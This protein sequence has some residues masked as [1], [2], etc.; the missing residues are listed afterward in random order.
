MYFIGADLSKSKVDVYVLDASGIKILHQ[1][2]ANTLVKLRVFF[3]THILKRYAI[4]P[5]QI[6]VCCENTGI[7]GRP[8]ENVCLAEGIPLWVE[9]ALRIKRASS[10]LRGKSDLLDSQR[11]A[12]Y[13]LRYQDRKRMVQ[14][15]STST[16]QL[17]GLLHARET[18]TN[19]INRLK[20][21][22][23]EACKFDPELYAVLKSSFK[24]SIQ[25]LKRQLDN[26]EQQI[27]QTLMESQELRS[28]VDLMRSIPGVGLIL[29]L[30]LI[31]ATDNFTAFKSPKQL[32]CHCG[33]VPFPNESG[34]IVKRAK[35]SRHANAKLKKLLH[36][37]AMVA[38]QHNPQL[39]AY[40]QRKVAEGKNKMLVLNAVRNKL[41]H[42]IYAVLKRGT[43]YTKLS[44][45]GAMNQEN[46]LIG[47]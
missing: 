19:S 3:R 36:M 9:N 14:P 38:I 8:L 15:E 18:L 25:S 10:Q 34:A 20:V 37:A 7:Y 31:E 26:V 43:P 24:R 28:Q 27:H 33:V 41:I 22:L 39:K 23:D 35:V 46:I 29:S 17:R 42:I 12:E 2:V 32:A 13:A 44:P 30:N 4:E 16:K 6:L 21:Q 11:I 40:Y 5:G 47:A 45:I 1:T